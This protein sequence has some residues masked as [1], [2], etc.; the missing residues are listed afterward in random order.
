MRW[1][2]FCPILRGGTYTVKEQWAGAKRLR[3]FLILNHQFFTS[4]L[5]LTMMD[6]MFTTLATV[7]H[8]NGKNHY[9]LN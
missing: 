7:K 8:G 2:T 5:F 3:Q 6:H 4:S 1:V 9:T